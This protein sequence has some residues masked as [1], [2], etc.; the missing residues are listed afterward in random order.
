VSNVDRF[1]D[2]VP[3]PDFRPRMVR[4]ACGIIGSFARPNWQERP[5]QES[6]TGRQS[7]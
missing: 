2:D 5:S 3:V 7:S 4:A 6:Q 1:A